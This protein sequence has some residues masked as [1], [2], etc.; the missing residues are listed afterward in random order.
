[1]PRIWFDGEVAETYDEDSAARFDPELLRTTVDVLADLAGEGRALELAIGTGRVAVPL[2]ERGVPV[3]GIELSPA[4]LAQLRAKTGAAGI[5]AVEGDMTSTRVEG[6]FGLVYLVYNTITNLTSRTSRSRAS[7]T[8][9]AT[10][11]LVGASWSRSTC[12]SSGCCPRASASG[13]SSRSPATTPTTSTPIPPRSCSGRTTCGCVR[14]GPTD[15][16][17]CRS[18]TSG[19]PSST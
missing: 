5:E 1:M 4:M 13:S 19:P 11:R 2:S 17:R 7:R 14:T 18:A 6:E 15:G 9:P 8:P 10:W 12:R 16:C 3:S